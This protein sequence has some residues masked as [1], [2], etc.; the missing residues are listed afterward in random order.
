MLETLD[1]V[2]LSASPVDNFYKMY[3]QGEF[4]T[5]LLG[6]LPEVEDCKNLKQDN[7]WH[8]YGCLDHILHSVEEINKLTG[9]LPQETRRML[10]Y[11][12]FL[13][14]IGK[15]SCHLRRYSKK[16]GREIDSFFNHNLASKKV[17]ERVLSK[18]RFSDEEK[19]A[20]EMFI[21]MHDIFMFITLK[22]DG[23]KFHHVL[24][25]EYLD[26]EIQKLDKVGDGKTLM[27]YLVLVGIA[28]NKAQ[29]PQMTK[30]SLHLLD[31]ITG[32]LQK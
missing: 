2:L 3:S 14:D 23:N 19:C 30:D 15:P 8:I 28:D 7:P 22:D 5:W 32:M 18:L 26:S 6:V 16:Y 29:N 12:M 1:R 27:K 10:A 31:V 17:A 4:K 21:E 24:T 9:N 11:T 25:P 13:H 20:M